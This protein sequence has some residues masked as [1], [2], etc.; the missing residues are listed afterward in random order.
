VPTADRDSVRCFFIYRQANAG[1]VMLT[2]CVFW[3]IIFPFLTEKDYSLNFVSKHTRAPCLLSLSLSL[4]FS[5]PGWPTWRLAVPT[6]QMLIKD[7][8]AHSPVD[9][10]S[11]SGSC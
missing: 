10:S 8:T 2:D 4:L 5:S 6:D 1:A 9:F 11:S 3:F 7:N